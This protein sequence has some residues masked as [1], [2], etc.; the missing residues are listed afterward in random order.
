MTDQLNPKE[1]DILEKFERG[2][3]R[4]AAGAESEM[5]TA[6]IAARSTFTKTGRVNFRVSGRLSD[7]RWRRPGESRVR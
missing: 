7:K 2:E 1:R 3:L 5:E 6:R 4:R